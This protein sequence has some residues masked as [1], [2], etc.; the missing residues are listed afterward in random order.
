MSRHAVLLVVAALAAG[1][2]SAELENYG[3]QVCDT[4]QILAGCNDPG[5]AC[6]TNTFEVYG[7][8][9]DNC[10]PNGGGHA[11]WAS[12]HGAR[13]GAQRFIFEF[14]N[15]VSSG[16]LTRQGGTVS[17]ATA[18]MTGRLVPGSC[19]KVGPSTSRNTYLSGCN[20]DSSFA[21]LDAIDLEMNFV[22]RERPGFGN[23]L[24]KN[25]NR[26]S[27]NPWWYNYEL[28][29]SKNNTMRGVAGGRWA[30]VL[31]NLALAGNAQTQPDGKYGV[32]YGYG[33]SQKHGVPGTSE[34]TGT[35]Y[36]ISSW[37]RYDSVSYPPGWSFGQFE[38]GHMSDG[39]LNLALFCACRCVCENITSNGTCPNPPPPPQPICGDGIVEGP[40]QCEPG[41]QAGQNLCCLSNC[42]FAASGTTCREAA[43]DCDV[44]ETCDGSSP[45]CPTDS[46]EPSTTTCSGLVGYCD[47]TDD[48]FCTGNSPTCP[49]V[50]FFHDTNVGPLWAWAFNVISFNNWLATT[51]DVEGRVA[52]RN[53]FEAGSGYSIGDKLCTGNGQCCDIVLH[54]NLFVGRNASWIS[55]E[56]Y[57]SRARQTPPCY[58]VEEV[59]FVG[60]VSF[61]PDG[62][63]PLTNRDRVCGECITDGCLD[64][65]F[66][67]VYNY[68]KSYSTRLAANTANTQYELRYQAIVIT[69]NSAT[70][71]RYYVDLDPADLNQATWW[72]L[73]GCNF[74]A[75]WVVNIGGTGDV[76]F[77]GGDLGTIVERTIFNIVGS[78][79]VFVRNTQ[80]PGNMLMVDAT[81]NQTGSYIAGNVV[82]GNGIQTWQVNKPNCSAFADVEVRTRLEFASDM[83]PASAPE[84]CPDVLF[85]VSLS[86]FRTGDVVQVGSGSNAETATISELL[87]VS[88]KPAL[89]FAADLKN[90]HNPG[91]EV[92][93][94]VSDPANAQRPAETPTQ[95]DA[96]CEE[97]VASASSM[98]VASVTACLFGAVA[99]LF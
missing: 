27:P 47:V 17:G 39:D 25:E 48:T 58:S 77:T 75:E 23:E 46:F 22:W 88:G 85:V 21:S 91:V 94:T 73:Q 13:W 5:H 52:V 99:V 61:G 95:T 38:L 50:P 41:T 86:Q 8:V 6:T 28:D 9:G 62:A 66:D 59:G 71:S 55:G 29:Q 89:R 16:I 98:L 74:G 87:I 76:T 56:L 79:T 54:H 83:G 36:G 37:I 10:G 51:S 84:G 26:C 12:R 57:P 65:E 69:C 72:L 7:A 93:H 2:A 24:L 67:A 60:G 34:S 1:R 82:V 70:D 63:S 31:I 11:Y 68:Y 53:N 18:K 4:Q 97:E 35:G 92:T 19:S 30:G 90:R 33:A 44:A 42:T 40:E 64:S 3:G 80:V 45:S 78:R 14:S 15:G 96:P 49:G 81:L 32:H 43:G 20:R